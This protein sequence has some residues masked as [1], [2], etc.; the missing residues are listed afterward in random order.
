MSQNTGPKASW[1]DKEVE[2]LVLYLHNH[3]STAGDGGSFTDPTFNE[4]VEHLV[5]Y[6]KSGPKKM[7]KWSRLSGQWY[8][9]YTVIET[10][11][12]LSDCH[13]DSTNGCSIQ[14]EDAGVVWEEYVK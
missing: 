7:G 14:G 13:W 4:A 11:Q 6:L 9:I 5:P 3:H 2:E 12:D 8:K 1:S 10:Y